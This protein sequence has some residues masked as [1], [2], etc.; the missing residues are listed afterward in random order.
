M[1]FARVILD[2][3]DEDAGEKVRG[4][5][6]L[7]HHYPCASR[8]LMARDK[9]YEA[10]NHPATPL[11]ASPKRSRTLTADG[12]ATPLAKPPIGLKSFDAEHCPDEA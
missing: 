2:K 5:I 11:D 7:F 4:Q 9:A 10:Q 8:H 12:A 3:G 6:H 1:P